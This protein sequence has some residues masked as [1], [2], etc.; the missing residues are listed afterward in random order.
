M[1]TNNFGLIPNVDTTTCEIDLVS[2]PTRCG[3]T[4]PFWI[5][6]ECQSNQRESGIIELDLDSLVTYVSAG[7]TPALITDSM[8][9]WN[10]EELIPSMNQNIPLY[11]EIASADFLGEYISMEVRIKLVDENDEP[12]TTDITSFV[13]Q[14]NCA[15]DPNDK[16]V[17]PYIEDYTNFTLPDEE[18]FYTIRFQNTGTD[19]AFNVRIEDR[20]DPSLDWE[21]FRFISASHDVQTSIDAGGKAIFRFDDIHLPDIGIDEQ[22]SQGYVKYAISIR[23]SLPES[24][25]AF[26]QA[27]I[28]FDFNDPIFTNNVYNVLVSEIPISYT[29]QAPFCPEGDDGF[30]LP[31]IVHPDLEYFWNGIEAAPE[32]YNLAAGDYHLEVFLRG[33]L[34]ADTT[35]SLAPI[36]SLSSTTSFNPE[37]GFNQD[38][39]ATVEVTGGTA[40]YS[41]EWNTIPVQTEE[42]AINLSAGSYEVIVRD[43][44]GCTFTVEVVVDRLTSIDLEGIV[45][46]FNLSPNP[47]QGD[48]NIEFELSKKSVWSLELSL[49]NGQQIFK[50]NSPL[51]GSNSLNMVLTDLKAGV[52]TIVLRTSEGVVSHKLV[53]I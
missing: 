6:Y 39:T 24:I 16:A 52:Y 21:T 25:Y 40:P 15:Y 35:I 33:H 8:L 34:A 38:G 48:V 50:K 7:V 47:T 32:N 53:V 18:L 17:T 5:N 49:I 19:T 14:I 12:I 26:N 37:N 22:G 11:F 2:G 44:E 4:V 46:I 1:V 43:A 36:S 9:V 20:L 28:Y 45:D 30:I 27:E 51:N 3:F 23:D 42:T 41:Y 10:I 13:S 29:T 31:S